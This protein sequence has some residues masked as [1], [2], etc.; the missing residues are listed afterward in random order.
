MRFRM[1]SLDVVGG[2]WLKKITKFS[3][4]S[5]PTCSETTTLHAKLKSIKTNK[6]TQTK[7]KH[8]L[9]LCFNY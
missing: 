8:P 6:V 5:I 1:P 4:P 9:H 2:R 3:I 7:E